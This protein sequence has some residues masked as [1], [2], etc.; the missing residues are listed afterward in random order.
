MN[1]LVFVP[2]ALAPVNTFHYRTIDNKK[3]RK[4]IVLPSQST[5][6]DS[7]IFLLSHQVINK[8]LSELKEFEEQT[9]RVVI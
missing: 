3:E 4:K 6:E 7:P 8:T 1:A 5:C 9:F 2:K